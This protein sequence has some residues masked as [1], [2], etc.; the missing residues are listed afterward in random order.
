MVKYCDAFC[1]LGGFSVAAHQTFPD[2]QC[3]WAID[4]DEA[5]S[6][7]FH[8]NFG[9]ECLGDILD[10]D[11]AKDVP[12]HDI[13]FGGFP[14]QPFSQSGKWRTIVGDGEHRANLFIP[15]VN[16]LRVKQPGFFVFENV[17]NLE[18]VKNKD[19]TLY[20]DTILSA[21]DEA[22]YDVKTQVLDAKNYCVPQHRERVFLVGALKGGKPFDFEFPKT[23]TCNV[24]AIE[25]ILETHVDDK[26]LIKNA[27]KNLKTLGRGA[28]GAI[29]PNHAFPSGTSRAE[30][31]QWIY[32]NNNDKPSS[33]T[34]ET[35]AAA[36]LYGDTP[37]GKARRTDKV[38]SRL[39]VSPTV[40][41][42][43]G[44]A[45]DSPQGLRLLTPRECARLQGFP[46]DYKLPSNDHAA[47]KQVGNAVCVPVVRAILES[48][49][50]HVLGGSAPAIVVPS[51]TPTKD[52]L[53]SAADHV[54]AAKASLADARSR[55]KEA[56]AAV[57]VA[58]DAYRSALKSYSAANERFLGE[59]APAAKARA[60]GK[61]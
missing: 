48:L 22:G 30:V 52:E 50:T 32:D 19:G 24:P 59:Y 53:K 49:S 3:V 13:L 44:P 10:T 35:E 25:D 11:P 60:A 40:V 55:A 43:S 4:F 56:D 17:D 46:D 54:A 20:M 12:D 42:F 51:G 26:Y 28:Q 21:I 14:C 29:P 37:S 9:I 31:V 61:I 36:I 47:Y 1:G 38:Y 18:R 5:V 27:W 39:G 7:T 41:A 34:G 45:V 57:V 33:R 16:I 58:E 6:K 8:N 2:S 23:P 15:L